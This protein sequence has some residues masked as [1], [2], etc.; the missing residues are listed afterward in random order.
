MG[1]K[2]ISKSPENRAEP[3][4]TTP[5]GPSAVSKDSTKITDSAACHGVFSPLQEI[6]A[7]EIDQG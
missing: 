7:K 3:R 5:S 2:V 4:I 6:G 1:S